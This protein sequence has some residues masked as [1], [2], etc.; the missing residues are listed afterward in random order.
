M[1]PLSSFWA[2]MA[3]ISDIFKFYSLIK[4]NQDNPV[5]LGLSAEK[6]QILNSLNLV[7]VPTEPDRLKYLLS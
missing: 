6:P 4:Q 2:G 7:K 3:D 1:L 5:E